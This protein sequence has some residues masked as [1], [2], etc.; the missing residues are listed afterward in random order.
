MKRAWKES[1]EGDTT[2]ATSAERGTS[3][4]QGPKRVRS[5]DGLTK[6]QMKVFGSIMIN[7]FRG[8]LGGSGIIV[9]DC[10]RLFRGRR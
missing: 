3:N 6:E 4:E 8:W 7:L 9:V 5:F 1:S 2:A 10:K